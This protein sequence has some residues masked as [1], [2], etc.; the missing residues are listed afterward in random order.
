MSSSVPKRHPKA[1][2]SLIPR[3]APALGGTDARARAWCIEVVV[4]V[5]L[6]RPARV[7]ACWGTQGMHT[8][9]HT[10][11]PNYL[12]R[13]H[14]PHSP[15]AMHNTGFTGC[16]TSATSPSTSRPAAATA[17]HTTAT[18]TV[19]T[20]PC[21]RR[22]GVALRFRPRR[23]VD[24]QRI[25]RQRIGQN[26]VPRVVAPDRERIQRDR[27][28]P[29]HRE[30]DIFEVGIHLHIDTCISRGV[31]AARTPRARHQ[32]AAHFGRICL[33][34]CRTHCDMRGARLPRTSHAARCACVARAARARA[35]SGIRTSDRAMDNRPVLQLDR[36]ALIVELHQEAASA[37][38]TYRT[39]FILVA[40]KTATAR[41]R[42]DT[43]ARGSTRRATLRVPRWASPGCSPC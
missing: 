33:R 27:L 20:A 5:R 43:A 31:G 1:I 38:T 2:F 9:A 13:P 21:G 14:T 3:P 25:E 7:H 28:T 42:D 39:N 4:G 8:L 11:T 15:T 26:P 17:T 18:A 29:T 6:S 35:R 34:L 23:I 36:D 22:I 40:A 30:L 10:H 19:A 37:R 24:Q 41:S 32:A 16:S 12:H